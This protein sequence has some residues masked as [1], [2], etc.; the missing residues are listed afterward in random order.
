[1]STTLDI[2]RVMMQKP[3]RGRLIYFIILFA[4]ETS[5]C[6]LGKPPPTEALSKAELDLRAASEA[7]AD[8][9]A[10]M[11]L[12]SAREKFEA[13]KKAMAAKRYDE[14]RRLAEI[15]QVEA[16]LAAAKAE[17]ELTRRAA[18]DLRRRI[19]SLRAESE[20]GSIPGP[21]PTAAKE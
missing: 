5:G 7:R 10:P 9:F 20:R 6:S 15:A 3:F 18:E 16:E 13:S 14:A 8:E 4:F 17:A 11:D 19:D 21:S 2:N 1:M 12:Q